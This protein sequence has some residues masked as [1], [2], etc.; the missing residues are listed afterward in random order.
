VAEDPGQIREAIAETRSEIADTV[1]ALGEKA[2]I[3]ARVGTT[4]QETTDEWKQ[5]A[6]ENPEKV[7][8]AA[9]ASAVVLVL[10][11]WHRRRRRHH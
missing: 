4:V 9:I 3:K 5:R 10:F 6:A 8:A 11:L 7:R 1:Q 2:D